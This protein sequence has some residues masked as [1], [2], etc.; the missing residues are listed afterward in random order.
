MERAGESGIGMDKAEIRHMLRLAA[1]TPLR[2]AVALSREGKA[3][4]LL[5]RHKPPRTLER[6]LKEGLPGS[7]L[8]RFGTLDVDADDPLLARFIVNKASPGMARKLAVALRGTGLRRVEIRTE[9][10]SET[11]AAEDED[12]D[13]ATQIFAVAHRI[14]RVRHAELHDELRVLIEQLPS[15]VGARRLQLVAMADAARTE[16]KQ[17]R[18]E[19]AGDAIAALRA[20]LTGG[21]QE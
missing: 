13:E 8:H 17:D 11:E 16:L 5:D 1:G 7:R 18:L 3:V 12:E 9:D 6:E 2:A 21:T 4:I 14:D 19:A 10:G 15:I 20:A